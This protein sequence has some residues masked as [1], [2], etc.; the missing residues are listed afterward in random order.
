MQGGGA[1]SPA[2]PRGA[3]GSPGSSAEK[4]KRSSVIYLDDWMSGGQGHSPP[5]RLMGAQHRPEGQSVACGYTPEDIAAA[6]FVPDPTRRNPY[7]HIGH[8]GR[9][10]N[11]SEAAQRQAQRANEGL[12]RMVATQA[13]ALSTR[14][15]KP[16]G[17]GLLDRYIDFRAGVA[18]KGLPSLGLSSHRRAEAAGDSARARTPSARR[19]GGGMGGGM[20]ATTSSRDLPPGMGVGMG[21]GMGTGMGMGMATPMSGRGGLPLGGSPVGGGAVPHPGPQ[22]ALPGGGGTLGTSEQPRQHGPLSQRGAGPLS[23]RGGSLSQRVSTA[24]RLGKKEG[25]TMPSTPHRGGGGGASHRAG[26]AG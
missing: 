26:G 13:S 17:G 12:S 23:Q 7:S 6:G 14:Q 22:P 4:G 25:G 20:A 15:I 8:Q 21:M 9:R 24:L 11:T 16:S 5:S 2:P 10:G 3:Q 19:G 1:S 18:A